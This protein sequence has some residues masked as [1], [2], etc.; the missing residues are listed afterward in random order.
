MSYE[1]WNNVFGLCRLIAIVN[2]YMCGGGLNGQFEL[3][4]TDDI[5][6]SCSRLFAYHHPKQCMRIGVVVYYIC[7]LSASEPSEFVFN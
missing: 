4:K 1:L 5:V 7:V 3:Q 2:S 6:S